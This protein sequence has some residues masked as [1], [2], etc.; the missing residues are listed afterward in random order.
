[1]LETVVEGGDVPGLGPLNSAYGS[2]VR[3]ENSPSAFQYSK[4]SSRLSCTARST[5]WATSSATVGEVICRP[6]STG[7]CPSAST[8]FSR[9][10]PSSGWA[11]LSR[12]IAATS[13]FASIGSSR[14][15][16]SNVSEYGSGSTS[17]SPLGSTSA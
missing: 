10:V 13:A 7:S 3:C 9:A 4:L 15:G 11:R 2:T 6:S 14:A 12:S 5:V 17:I 8:T 16:R 1:M